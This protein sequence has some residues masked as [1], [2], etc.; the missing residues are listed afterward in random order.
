MKKLLTVFITT[1]LLVLATSTPAFASNYETLEEKL[2]NTKEEFLSKHN[3]S[4]ISELSYDELLD[5]FE[6][7]DEIKNSDFEIIKDRERQEMQSNSRAIGVWKF[8]GYI[9]VT[10]DSTTSGWAHGHAGI[11]TATENTVIEA[12]KNVGVVSLPDRI[13][14]YWGK[15]NSSVLA[16]KQAY[17][18]DYTNAFVYANNRIGKQYGF[19][20]LNPNDFYCSELVHL[21]WKNAGFTIGPA[22]GT[23]LPADLYTSSSTYSV[24]TY[25]A[26]Y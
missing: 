7:V 3:C 26:G 12:N 17:T 23:V 24:Q 4:N 2:N 1:L 6:I 14:T 20:P 11:G 13:S 22:I 15:K 21:A 25:N 8:K 19:D 18:S 16:V 5:L 9:F 10:G